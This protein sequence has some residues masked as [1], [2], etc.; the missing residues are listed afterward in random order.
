M[1]QK[2]SH[3]QKHRKEYVLGLL[4]LFFCLVPSRASNPKDPFPVS[5]SMQPR[6]QFWMNVFTIYSIHDRIFLDA[7]NPARIY[8]VV[9]IQS[10]PF[11]PE[12][13]REKRRQ[14]LSQEK[15]RIAKILY[16]LGNYYGNAQS[17]KAEERRVYRLF[18]KRPKR[19][20]FLQ[21]I[22]RIR[23]QGG[24]KEAF[25]EGLIRSGQYL[26]YIQAIL[27]EEGVPAD[28][29][30]LPHVESSF[31]PHAYSKMGAAGLWQFT[32]GT[33]KQYLRINRNI[34]ERR[35][36]LL[37][38]RAAAKLL[39]FNY[40]KLGSWPLAITAYNYGHA[41]MARAVKKV[42]STSLDKIIEKHHSK[43]FGFACKNFYAEFVAASLV[44]KNA[45]KYFGPFQFDEPV[46]LKTVTLKKP[47]QLR[48]L[49]NTFQ[50]S[51]QEIKNLNPAL[52]KNVL[53]KKW[54]I[55]SGYRLRLPLSAR[56]VQRNDAFV[57][58]GIHK[59]RPQNEKTDIQL[60]TKP[61]LALKNSAKLD[62]LNPDIQN[63]SENFGL[64]ASASDKVRSAP[65]SHVSLKEKE[66]IAKPENPIPVQV[67]KS[68][69][70][71]INEDVIR[72]YGESIVV[73]PEETLGHFAD[74]LQ[75]PTRKLRQLNGL[76]FNRSIRI[77]QT[78]RLDFSRVSHKNFESRRLA[79]HEELRDHFFK[80]HR[81][82]G[83]LTHQMRRGET[84]WAV[85]NKRFDIPLWLIMDYNESKDLDQIYP[86]EMVKIPIVSPVQNGSM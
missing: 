69:R 59:A 16:F 76:P 44:T 15:K 43:R 71:D 20:D 53:T 67:E 70:P 84:L 29:A 55:P 19:K 56:D 81:V 23:I 11:T 42:R 2:T 3:F 26:P 27:E 46:A 21:A 52:G 82:E 66:T 64:Y 32:R 37:A 17:L 28:L 14:L 63:N 31:N 18:G 30:Y 48:H 65:L 83:S 1:I 51:T 54:S 38:S 9:N 39:K 41:G 13:S 73:Q 12:T 24:M 61:V 4:T 62:S 78:L 57:F 5:K 85:A 36:P 33:G 40:Q 22:Y 86:G 79:Y 7:E 6:V 10:A 34:D 49:Q 68:V 60:K 58:S 80:S 75:I 72:V 77:G 47:C 45:S 8:K 50:V 25:K 74:W 35:D